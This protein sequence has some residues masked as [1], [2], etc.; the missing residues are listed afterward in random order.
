MHRC[1]TCDASH[2]T[3]SALLMHVSVHVR[4]LPTTRRE[5]RVERARVQRMG[6]ATRTTYRT[7]GTPLM[8][9]NGMTRP[10]AAIYT[11]G[12]TDA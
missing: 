1:N 12:A 8:A 5:R 6:P 3:Y 2:P 7:S 10:D 9:R 4:A 11:R